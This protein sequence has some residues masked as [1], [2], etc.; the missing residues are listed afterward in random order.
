M[1]IRLW[2][3]TRLKKR[4]REVMKLLAD[5]QHIASVHAPSYTCL[6]APALSTKPHCAYI[7]RPMTSSPTIDK[8]YL[9]CLPPRHVKIIMA[10]KQDMLQKRLFDYLF[11]WPNALG[12]EEA[13]PYSLGQGRNL[14]SRLLTGADT[15]RKGFT[16]C[17][18][19]ISAGAKA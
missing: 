15:H 7:R 2:K 5:D 17:L 16:A 13:F 1:E 12:Y 14:V 9:P 18:V 11:T 6:R 19:N 8:H 4:R 3:S 10:T